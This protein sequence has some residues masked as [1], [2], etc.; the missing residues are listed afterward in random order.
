M[1]TNQPPP[2]YGFSDQPGGAPGYPGGAPMAGPPQGNGM[3]VAGLVL[4][5]LALVLFFLTWP[6]WILAV[7]GIIFGA[8]GISKG[9]KVGKGKGMAIAGLVCAVL[10]LLISIVW[11]M[12]IVSEMKKASRRFGE[13]EQVQPDTRTQADRTMPAPLSQV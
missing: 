4:G 5:I 10:G 12:F 6:S 1:A 9:N 7:L 2:N 8:L 11:T 13:V 3:A